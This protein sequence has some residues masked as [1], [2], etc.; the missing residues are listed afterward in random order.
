MALS[1]TEEFPSIRDI[2]VVLQI[3][4]LPDLTRRGPKLIISIPRWLPH[5][6]IPAAQLWRGYY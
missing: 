2:D 1:L 4:V 3:L 5:Y 6:T